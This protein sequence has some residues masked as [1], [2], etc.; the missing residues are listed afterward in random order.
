M[1]ATFL[2]TPVL[3]PKDP[4]DPTPSFVFASKHPKV[5]FLPAPLVL[6]SR[7]LKKCFDV[8]IVGSPALN[9]SGIVINTK[10]FLHL[11]PE[12]LVHRCPQSF[13][14]RPPLTQPLL[15]PGPRSH[16]QIL[17]TFTQGNNSL[18]HTCPA[19]CHLLSHPS[20]TRPPPSRTPLLSVP[21]TTSSPLNYSRV[22]SL[23]VSEQLHS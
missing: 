13:L 10:A 1:S 2:S 17:N 23:L 5:H 14:P 6:H 20:R 12:N 9:Y 19:S 21:S 3:S 22:C 7:Y 15:F 4:Q 11:S 8:R 16:P 18:V